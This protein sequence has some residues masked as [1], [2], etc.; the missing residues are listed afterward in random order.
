MIS[1]PPFQS[2]PDRGQLAINGNWA[3]ALRFSRG[4]AIS[5]SVV[6]AFL[7]N[8]NE[9]AME[10]FF[11]DAFFGVRQLG[12]TDH[13]IHLVHS[14]AEAMSVA[15]SGQEFFAKIEHTFNLRLGDAVQFAEIGAVDAWKNVGPFRIDIPT[16][17]SA[18]FEKLWEQ[19]QAAPVYQNQTHPKAIEFAFHNGDG[20]THWFAIPLS[21]DSSPF[22]IEQRQ[23]K[24][25]L[26]LI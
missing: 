12:A 5:E 16:I 3:Q 20:T 2:L 26:D 18:E 11:G 24:K 8:G 7:G 10:A 6:R 17:A 15:H 4:E 23:L 9:V 25:A 21:R 13:L 1:Y 14:F 19:V 22:A